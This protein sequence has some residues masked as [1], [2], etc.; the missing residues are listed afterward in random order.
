[1]D[2]TTS[3]DYGVAANG[4]RLHQDAKSPATVISRRDLNMLIWSL[5]EVLKA[6]GIS[7]KEFSPEIGRAH[8]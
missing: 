1:M 5:M 3:P 7:G 8:V 4:Q 2:Y 6:A